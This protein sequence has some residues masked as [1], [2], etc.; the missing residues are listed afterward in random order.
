METALQNNYLTPAG[1]PCLTAP[2]PMQLVFNKL[3]VAI[4]ITNQQG[5]VLYCNQTFCDLF[6]LQQLPSELI[7]LEHHPFYHHILAP[8]LLQ[9]NGQNFLLK[10]IAQQVPY[11]RKIVEGLHH[12][13]VGIDYLPLEV[14]PNQFLH[15]FIFSNEA[16]NI[17][18]KQNI[19][20]KKELF[21]NILT[22][23][24]SDICVLSTEFTYLFINPIAVKDPFKR[25][26]MI[27][28]TDF[29]LCALEN[30]DLSLAEDRKK[31]YQQALNT[32]QQVQ[33]EE[34]TTNKAGE[35]EF[36]FRKVWPVVNQ[37]GEV[38][39]LISYG[40][41]ILERKFI[42]DGIQ[43]SEK[44]YLDL[45][46]FS[47]AIICT[48]DLDGNFLTVNPAL[49]N[50][51]G[52]KK[53]E[54]IGKNLRN[55]LPLEDVESF[56]DEYTEATV[57]DQKAK[58]VIRIACKSR[59]II[60][61][62]Y[63]SFK[64]EEP[65]KEPYIIGFA[66]NI[67]D[68][69]NTEKELKN[70][71]KLSEET[72][73]LKERFLANMSHEIRTPMNGILG[74]ANLLNKTTLS[75]DQQKYINII[76]ESAQNLMAIVNDILDIE[77][78]AAGEIG[79]E[80]IPF[81]VVQKT[82]SIVNFFEYSCN[83]NGILLQFN[84][85]IGQSFT[86]IGDPTRYNQIL[87]N[88]VSNAIKF[89]NQGKI[90]LQLSIDKQEDN[91]VNLQCEVIDT[92][93]GM[94]ED[95][96]TKIFEPFKQAYS[97]TTRKYGGSGLGLAITKN[98]VELQGGYITVQ[99]KLGYGSKFSFNINYK[100][101]EDTAMVAKENA[102][103]KPANHQLGKLRVLLAEDNEVN[104]LLASSILTYGGLETRTATTGNEVLA[105]LNKEDFDVILM[106]IQMPEK[107]GLE[108]TLEIRA[109]DN[110]IKKNIPII[111]LTANALKGEEKKY[112]EVGMDDYLTKPF[113]E[114]EL[115][116]VI[117]RVINNKGLF[118]RQLYVANLNQLTT[119]LI[120]KAEMENDG[121]LYDMNSLNEVSRGNADFLL[122]L[123]KIFLNTIPKNSCEMVE[124][125]EQKNW[126]KVSALAHKLKS[127]IDTMNIKTIK[128]EIRAIE[129]NA[130]NKADLPTV[131]RHV[132]KVNVVIEKT[133]SQLRQQFSL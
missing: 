13:F 104:Q 8:N 88:L 92:G 26:W 132:H 72:A 65:A 63:E 67:T 89:T 66:Q 12:K 71:K 118:G 23:L 108:A 3:S 24:P 9:A 21:E 99:S 68:R 70:A 76:T 59:E 46:N 11:S 81:D 6:A 43:V 50:L 54:I 35:K 61:L 5:N 100:K 44:R 124:A 38:E 17:E 56:N 39:M 84:N 19:V 75:P 45:F 4:L 127:T 49:C 87:N 86:I 116:E 101:S 34:E 129:I 111:A 106:D 77:K 128:Q 125:A 2:L 85:N 82:I 80:S 15:Q 107:S 97:E 37:Q 95:K 48:H 57:S 14:N 52:Y 7:G 126:D 64:V 16:E 119:T 73:L 25:N 113:K 123:T 117:S 90:T 20:Q 102:P 31:I 94:E 114:K 60:Y 109:L 28:K 58:G 32:R 78:I 69:V 30:I 131:C 51:T 91:S 103:V 41:N 36:H 115:F 83:D 27:G 121:L 120:N 133:A 10:S 47:Q 110:V 62:L 1:N 18:N 53:E 112:R 40:L 55:F 22:H 42:E 105:L 29:D 130:K 33:W 74:M 122:T 79:I 93:I 96:L 98:L